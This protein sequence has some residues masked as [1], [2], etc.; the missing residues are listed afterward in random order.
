MQ[1]ELIYFE[2]GDFREHIGG[3]RRTDGLIEPRAFAEFYVSILVHARSQALD[4]AKRL[5]GLTATLPLR[6]SGHA[7]GS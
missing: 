3:R 5:P 4:R 6:H 7:D 2:N 1:S